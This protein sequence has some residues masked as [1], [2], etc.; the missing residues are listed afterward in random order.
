MIGLIKPGGGLVP[1]RGGLVR[2]ELAADGLIQTPLGA[3]DN[4]LL[5]LDYTAPA[6]QAFPVTAAA[7][8]A[9]MPNAGNPSHIWL[10]D[11]ASGNLIDE[12]ASQALNSA[13]APRYQ[14]AAVGLYD[15]TDM[16]SA[17][18]VASDGSAAG[19]VGPT[20]GF[21]DQTTDSFAIL[22]VFRTNGGGGDKLFIKGTSGTRYEMRVLG[23]GSV[24]A[25]MS[26]T[27]SSNISVAGH[28]GA[29][30]CALWVIDRAAQVARLITD[31]GAAT[32]ADISDVLSLTNGSTIEC[33]RVAVSD[34]ESQTRY[35]ALFE[36]AAAE[37]IVQADFDA[38]WT[39]ASDPGS[40]QLDTYTRA[41]LTTT[42]V[43]DEPGFGL[44]R[45]KY[46]SG[47][48]AHKYVSAFAHASKFGMHVGDARTNL[49]GESADFGT[50]WAP[51][52]ITV[53]ADDAESPDGTQAAD[54]LAATADNGHVDY[55]LVSV[56]STEYTA[57]VDL[58]RG[59]GS[60]VSGRLIIYDETGAAELAS[61]VFTAGA[62]VARV[63]VTATTNVGQISTS[64][65]VEIDTNTEEVLAWEAGFAAGKLTSAIC[66]DGGSDSRVA[67]AAQL[68]NTGGSAYLSSVSGELQ[69]VFALDTDED[70]ATRV[71]LDVFDNAS[72]NDRML[73]EQLAAGTLRVRIWD[74]AGTLK[75][76]ITA[77]DPGNWDQEH[78]LRI[79]WDSTDGVDGNAENA[80]V[81][82]DGVRTAGAA[83]SWTAGANADQIRIGN[84]KG[85][86]IQLKG[87]IATLD[88][89]DA[90]RPE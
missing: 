49:V 21:F 13:G 90:P 3:V 74:G 17:D 9:L 72:N 51:T 87:T 26:S 34:H 70:A 38:F 25:Y 73:V 79:R 18:A 50:T 4:Q 66:T 40:P 42:E 32:D 62:N 71:V 88:V 1:Y 56:A 24:R 67:T 12:V 75:Q 19:F 45:A 11:E 2:S 14:Q 5:A 10:C 52:N 7:L 39:H 57:W 86:A 55:V 16:Y 35:V 23:G 28:D 69:M 41:S 48:F 76:T 61:Q 60:D 83:T 8:A 47:H 59:G 53:T 84:Q 63:F 54:R 30:H 58:S 6:Q 78:T 89:W 81:I 46:G 22:V 80:D 15:G 65:R 29:W 77:A 44:R 82:L 36:G 31:Q 64:V 27:G 37:G 20:S 43:G 33:A 85:S 68:V